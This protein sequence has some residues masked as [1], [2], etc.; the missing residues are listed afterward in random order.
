MS[1][2]AYITNNIEEIGEAAWNVLSAGQPFQSYSWYRFGE[3]A[4]TNAK[5]IHVILSEDGLAIARASFWCIRDEPLA[6]GVAARILKRWPLLVCRSPLSSVTSLILPNPRGRA[7]A[8]IVTIGRRLRRQEG[9]SLLIFDNLDTATARAIPQAIRYSFEMPGTILHVC[10]NSFDEYMASLPRKKQRDIRHNLR[11]I[12][13]MGIVV[14][15]HQTV[16]D[17]DEAEHLYRS[18]EARKGTER[19]QWV[20]TMWENMAMA[21]GTWIAA[22]NA[23]GQLL[24]CGTT[25]EDNAAQL[26]TNMGHDTT[27]YSYL[28]VLYE[29]IRLGLERGIHSF[30][31]G[32][33]TYELKRRLGFSIFENDSVAITF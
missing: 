2:E 13:E 25:F 8:E 33:T 27:P 1:L 3:R 26:E 29:S 24:A 5:P 22:R 23:S 14:T 18:L 4:M 15:R 31:W 11:K 21:N 20:R 16:E 28:A 6:R 10:G 32:A 12:A 9:C 7:L 30:Y 17:L 19:N